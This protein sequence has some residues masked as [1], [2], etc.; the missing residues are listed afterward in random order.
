MVLFIK[1]ML[2]NRRKMD[3]LKKK[4]WSTD[5]LKIEPFLNILFTSRLLKWYLLIWN[6][7]S[8]SKDRLQK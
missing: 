3:H 6:A 2:K 5:R 4:I 1:R 7:Y 8:I